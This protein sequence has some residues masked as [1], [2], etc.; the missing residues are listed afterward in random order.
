VDI[1]LF[2]AWI[3]NGN[4]YAAKEEVDQAMSAY[5]NAARLFLGYFFLLL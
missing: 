5:R 2:C 3:G 4:V 1:I